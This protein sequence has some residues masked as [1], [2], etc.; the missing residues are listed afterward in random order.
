MN[1]SPGNRG[2]ELITDWTGANKAV[3]HGVGSISTGRGKG[4]KKNE[5]TKYIAIRHLSEKA[6]IDLARN[7]KRIDAPH[8]NVIRWN[9]EKISN[10][11]G[12]GQWIGMYFGFRAGGWHEFS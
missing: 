12:A 3:N 10:A 11:Q 9:T 1:V 8:F 5:K 7:F 6:G 2:N 4:E